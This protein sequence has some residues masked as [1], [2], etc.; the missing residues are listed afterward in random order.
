MGLP[1]FESFSDVVR[2]IAANWPDYVPEF[3]TFL[4]V[5]LVA[6]LADMGST[7]CVMQ[8]S[9]PESELHPVIR[10]MSEQLGPVLGPV[11]GKA[12]QFLGLVVLTLLLRPRARFIF[13]P[14][15]ISYTAAACYNLWS[16]G[17]LFP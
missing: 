7:I 10:C 2:Y 17:L 1:P 12:W 11:C 9:G 3:R 15:A 8:M 4:I 14:A 13:V 5:V 16:S 6:S